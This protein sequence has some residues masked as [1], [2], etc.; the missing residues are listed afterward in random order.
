MQKTFSSNIFPE[1]ENSSKLQYLA[2]S[3][4]NHNC[5]CRGFTCHVMTCSTANT[6]A[7]IGHRDLKNLT[8]TKHPDLI[9]YCSAATSKSGLGGRLISLVKHEQN[10]LYEKPRE[11]YATATHTSCWGSLL[12]PPAK[13][14]THAHTVGGV[15][16]LREDMPGIQSKIES[17]ATCS[18]SAAW[19]V[20]MWV[21]ICIWIPFGVSGAL[22][23]SSRDAQ[24][25]VLTRVW[26]KLCLHLTELINFTI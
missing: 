17:E 5:S 6:K 1:D 18:M 25:Q 2:A 24:T 11:S 23:V 13:L 8:N 19:R 16:V 7:L 3:T 4:Q 10:K 26:I 14:H 9:Y 15:G 22:V 12:P 20:L 21:C